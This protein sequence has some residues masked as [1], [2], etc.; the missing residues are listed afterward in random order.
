MKNT[1]T[2]LENLHIEFLGLYF[3]LII[4]LIGAGVL[5]ALWYYRNTV[6]PVSGWKK[7]ALVSLR[8]AAFVLLLI[9]LAEPVIKLLATVSKKSRT[10]VLYDTSSSMDQKHD[11]QRKKD[12]LDAV[13]TIRS[14]LGDNGAYFAFDSRFRDLGQE[15]VDF[16]GNG[17]D[18]LNAITQAANQEDVSSILLISDGRWNLGEDPSGSRLTYEIPVHTV[19]VGSNQAVTDA[20]ITRISAAHVGHEGEY[21]PVEMVITSTK[22]IPVP[23]PVE[24]IEN[25]RIVASGTMSLRDTKMAKM[26]LDIPLSG[27]GDHLFTVLIKPADDVY[28][29]NNTRSFT[30]HVVKSSFR[31]LIAADKPSADLAFIR[32][33]VEDNDSFELEIITNRGTAGELMA[34]FP[35]DLTGYDALVLLNWFGSALTSQNA[36]TVKNWVSSGGGLWILG[37]SAP[38]AGAENITA[39]LPVQFS[40]S[41]NLRNSP[42]SLEL[43]ETG[44]IHFITSA[45]GSGEN[46]WNI[47]PPLSSILH[48][49]KVSPDGRILAHAVI[50]EDGSVLPAI[51]TGKFGVG[52][53]LVIPLSGIWRWQLMMEG[54]GK[55]GSYFS[56]FVHGTVNWLTSETETSPLTVTTDK[57]AYLGGQEIQFEARLYDSV[58]SPVSGAEIT[59]TIDNNPSS[60]MILKETRP[61]FYTGTMRGPETG[62]HSYS[63]LAYL[64]GKQYAE[65]SDT[66]MVENFS[67]EMLNPEPD[68]ELMGIIATRSGGISVTTAGIDSILTRLIPETITERY[69]NT[70]DFHLNPIIPLV[71]ILILTIEWSLRKYRGMM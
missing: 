25:N 1:V 10:A 2:H 46:F 32:R 7:R 22:E 65:R 64:G 63:A 8:I 5:F 6:P 51:V 45:A 42:F 61:A 16:R 52:K 13:H 71:L 28:K 33:A 53:V 35:D 31:I 4:F 21:L 34:P 36:E 59:L 70:Y 68:P 14:H 39:M 19:T 37:S 40:S 9:T 62:M 23:F 30:V 17:T 18:M 11:P 29:E 38:D 24:I 3:P 58:Y 50:T 57:T 20:S 12:A 54:A 60:K 56:H 27:H 44:R 66:F 49:A 48:V 55:G 26:N 15:D 67:L 43:T 47:L 41:A 69:E